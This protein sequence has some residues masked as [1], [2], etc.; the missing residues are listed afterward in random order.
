MVGALAAN[1]SGYLGGQF[2]G[3]HEDADGALEALDHEVVEVESDE[4]G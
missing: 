1:E 3:I 4:E 2:I